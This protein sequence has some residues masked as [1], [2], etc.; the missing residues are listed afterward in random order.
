LAYNYGTAYTEIL[1]LASENPE[2]AQTLSGHPA[3]LKAEV[4]YGIRQEMAQHLDDVVFRRTE[5]G[6]EGLPSDETLQEIARLAARELG[7]DTTQIARE[8]EHVREIYRPVKPEATMPTAD[9]ET[10]KVT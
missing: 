8:I 6:P 10:V 7:W 1:A 9:R 3:I 5:L 2:L 4:V